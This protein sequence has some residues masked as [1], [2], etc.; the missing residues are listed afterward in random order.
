[1][2]HLFSSLIVVLFMV[3]TSEF[4]LA[5]DFTVKIPSTDNHGGLFKPIQA[6]N[7]FQFQV[8]VT[9]NL[10]MADTI[11]IDKTFMGEVQSWVSIDDNKLT[12]RLGEKLPFF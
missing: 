10:G 2:K 7:S 5:Q 12:S 1:M 11:S 9:N 3:T 6:G 4:I 8:S